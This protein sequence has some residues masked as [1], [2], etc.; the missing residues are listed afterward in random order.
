[1]EL[2]AKKLSKAWWQLLVHHADDSQKGAYTKK[3]EK[4][5]DDY[6]KQKA[7]EY[8]KRC[9]AAKNAQEN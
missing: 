5:F 4:A 8:C 9:S 7:N 1:M 6:A 3:M 2:T